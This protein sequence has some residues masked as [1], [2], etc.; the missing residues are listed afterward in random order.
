MSR[1]DEY[2]AKLQ[3]A[4]LMAVERARLAPADLLGYD[5]QGRPATQRLIIND[6]ILA[7]GAGESRA[8]AAEGL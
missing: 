8:F 6:V 1:H 2:I 3:T 5:P 4:F 7:Q